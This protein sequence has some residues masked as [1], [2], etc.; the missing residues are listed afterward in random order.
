MFPFLLV[1][2]LLSSFGALERTNEAPE[3]NS[4]NLDWLI[5]LDNQKFLHFLPI[6]LG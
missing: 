2:V 1:V 4:Q 3:I 6:G 5:C